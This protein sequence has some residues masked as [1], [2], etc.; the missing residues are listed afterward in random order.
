MSAHVLITGG[1]GF[2]G[3]ALVKAMTEEGYLVTVLSRDMKSTAKIFSTKVQIIDKL[4]NEEDDKH[5]PYDIIINLAG[6]T[7]SQYWTESLK[8][9]IIDSRKESNRLIVNYIAKAKIK[10]SLMIAASGI[11]YYGVSLEEKFTEK[12]EPSKE[13]ENLFIVSLCKEIEKAARNAEEF[14]VRTCFLRTGVVLEKD[15]GILAKLLTPYKLGAGGKLGSGDQWLSW[16]HRDDLIGAIF[17]IISH[18]HIHGPVNITSPNPVTNEEFTEIL[19]KVLKRPA[20]INLPKF[21]VNLIFGQMGKELLLNGQNVVPKILIDGNFNYKYPT[22][23][24][25]LKAIFK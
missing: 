8:Q 2:V 5:P 16:I 10:P 14:K 20:F 6:E 23:Q 13:N 11:G 25:A 3:K 1:S 19:A 18:K 17:H 12:S 24:D 15:G 22:L 9:K 7:I 21:Y 4:S